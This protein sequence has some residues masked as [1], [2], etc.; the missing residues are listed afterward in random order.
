MQGF[1]SQHGGQAA[2]RTRQISMGVPATRCWRMEVGGRL[3]VERLDSEHSGVRYSTE[4]G[5]EDQPSTEELTS[6]LR[7]WT[8]DLRFRTRHP[9]KTSGRITNSRLISSN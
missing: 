9:R 8:L 3:L 4:L 7:P 2:R 1:G 5:S 6:D